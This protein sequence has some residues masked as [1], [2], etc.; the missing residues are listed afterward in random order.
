MLKPVCYAVIET[1][2][3]LQGRGEIEI[4]STARR[5]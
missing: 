1:P 2:E 5:M 3:L 4:R